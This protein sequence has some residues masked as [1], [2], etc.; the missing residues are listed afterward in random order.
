MNIIVNILVGDWMYLCVL[1]GAWSDDHTSF[2]L[3]LFPR[4]RKCY[5][6]GWQ[7]TFTLPRKEK[8]CHLVT[9]EV[10]SHIGPGLK[11]V[12]VCAATGILQDWSSK[13]FVDRLGCYTSSCEQLS[14][15]LFSNQLHDS[16]QHTSAGLTVN[17][18]FDKGKSFIES[19][20]TLSWINHNC[21]MC[22]KVGPLGKV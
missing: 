7:T 14:S 20:S 12:Q 1:N 6:M 18:N 22:A 21:Q 3:N 11:G 19:R 16:R 10:L 4:H 15:D 8:G 13:R 17:E 2:N 5:T 9:D